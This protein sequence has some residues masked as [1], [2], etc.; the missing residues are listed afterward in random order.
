MIGDVLT[1]SI[2]FEAIKTKYPSSELH[3]LINSHTVPVIQHNPFI[4]KL[5]I[6]SPEIES[7]KIK[8]YKFLKSI[9]KENYDVVIDVYGKL[10]SALISLFSKAPIKAA[11]Y[12]KTT[13]FIY[14]HP[15]KR[16]KIPNHNSSLAIENRMKLLESIDVQFDNYHPK[17]FL[18]PS[19]IESA[20]KYLESEFI[21]L[22]KP[23][24]M[25]SVLGSSEIKTYPT[26]YMAMFIDAIVNAKPDAQLLFNYIPKQIDKAKEIY[27]LCLTDT[28]KHIH[29]NVFGKS[30]REFLA[31]THH[32]DALLGN[33]GGANNMAKALGIPT[34]TLFSPYLNKKNWFGENEIPKHVAVHISD[35]MPFSEMD[36]MAAKKNPKDYYMKFKP[37]YLLPELKEFLKSTT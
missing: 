30:L 14:S 9:Q 22:S 26:A 31:I 24:Y 11:Y 12:K 23:L 33:E 37:D 19:E 4:D 6:I 32:C 21:N 27:D 1:S 7:S 3:Y 18:T 16:L 28:K 10:G 8:F 2:L 13:D 36:I 20:K 25:I 17:I 5:Q 15:I 35:Y 34:F 29:F